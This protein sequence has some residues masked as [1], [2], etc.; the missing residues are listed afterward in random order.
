MNILVI[1]VGGTHI[2]V[3]AS[4]RDGDRLVLP[5]GPDMTAD[6]M[7]GDVFKA[8]RRWTYDY[9]SIGYPGPVAHGRITREPYNLG[10]G[11]VGFDFAA[12]FKRPVR[13]V[14][15][16]AMQALGSYDGGNMLFLGLGTGLGTAL[17]IDGTL[18]PMELSHLPYRKG[19]TYEDY[20]G[21]AGLKRL[22]KRKWRR[23][24][25]DVVDRLRIALQADYVVLGG[26]NA[27]LLHA[28]PPDVRRGDNAN[29]FRGGVRL[30]EPDAG[31]EHRIVAA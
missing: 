10:R 15:D 14:N 1:D 3:A 11:W 28:L 24:V 22:G 18:V 13:I 17:V 26:G 20:V 30:W 25:S 8:V 21:L 6:T 5:S 23:Y 19:R 7:A 31:S 2:K 9:V 27:R 4:N 12:Y 29:A 16:A